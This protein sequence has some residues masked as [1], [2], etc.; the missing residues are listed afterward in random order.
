MAGLWINLSEKISRQSESLWGRKSSSINP[1]EE[2]EEEDDRMWKHRTWMFHWN[3]Y[4]LQ[5]MAPFSKDHC[6]VHI[7]SKTYWCVSHCRIINKMPIKVLQRCADCAA[8]NV[9]WLRDL[10]GDRSPVN[11]K[12]NPNHAQRVHSAVCWAASCPAI[13]LGPGGRRER[14][15]ESRLREETKSCSRYGTRLK[16]R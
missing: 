10:K 3:N 5:K 13:P 8:L 16:R 9:Y 4:C 15:R 7:W 12:E 6:F 11:I 1:K 14:S 2:E